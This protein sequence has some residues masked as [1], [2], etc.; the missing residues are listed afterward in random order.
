MKKDFY[1]SG[2]NGKKIYCEL[3]EKWEHDGKSY[4]AY[5]DEDGDFLVSY[6]KETENGFEIDNISDEKDALYVQTYLA[7]YSE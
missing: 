6:F 2:D 1:I 5:L 7:K 4:I 3:V